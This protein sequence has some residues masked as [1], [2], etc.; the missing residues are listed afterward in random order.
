MGTNQTK[1]WHIHHSCSDNLGCGLLHRSPLSPQYE[2]YRLR[3]TSA[4][5]RLLKASLW[6]SWRAFGPVANSMLALVNNYGSALAM[7]PTALML[8]R[9]LS[10]NASGGAKG[11]GIACLK[12]EEYDANHIHQ[13]D[14]C[15]CL[16]DAPNKL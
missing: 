5:G 1:G 6:F 10:T 11:P 13:K 7:A 3:Y 16:I 9:L 8:R 12:R 4:Y 14:A 15:A 2:T